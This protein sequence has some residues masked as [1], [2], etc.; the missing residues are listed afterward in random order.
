MSWMTSATV[1]GSI[2]RSRARCTATRLPSGE[3]APTSACTSRRDL[4]PGTSAIAPTRRHEL[5]AATAA[6]TPS[7]A[8][9]MTQRRRTAGSLH[10]VTVVCV[11]VIPALGVAS[12]FQLLQQFLGGLEPVSRR[13]QATHDRVFE[14]RRNRP[15]GA[16]RFDRVGCLGDSAREHLLRGAAR[17]R[18][19]PEASRTPSPRRVDSLR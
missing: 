13:L 3:I 10:A 6:T 19:R 12:A 18:G 1:H 4:H 16:R 15:A 8:A 17:E 11:G 14:L 5:Q 9:G 7:A 2:R